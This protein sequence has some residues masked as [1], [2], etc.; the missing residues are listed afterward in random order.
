MAEQPHYGAREMHIEWNDLQAGQVI[1]IGIVPKFSV[2]PG[3]VWRGAPGI[4][5]DNRLIYEELLGI[6]P[7]E[8]KELRKDKVI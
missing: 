1:G 8:L 3:K 5:N 7:E 6:G 2:T 4:G